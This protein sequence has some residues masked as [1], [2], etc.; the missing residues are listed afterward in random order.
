MDL[1]TAM[2]HFRELLMQVQADVQCDFVKWIQ[3]SEEF[4]VAYKSNDD[5]F[6]DNIVDDIR[7]LVPFDATFSS[8][9]IV[10]PSCGKV[11]HYVN[12]CQI[13]FDIGKYI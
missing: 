1:K 3:E 10:V 4:D 2:S 7:E 5:I 6:L 9:N 12:N 13:Y 8:E 11:R